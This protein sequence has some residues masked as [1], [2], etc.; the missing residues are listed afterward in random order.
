MID[1]VKNWGH[2]LTEFNE[3]QRKKG[4]LIAK[5]RLEKFDE[6]PAQLKQLLD[7]DDHE[8]AIDFLKPF[9]ETDKQYDGI[10]PGPLSKLFAILD[11]DDP[12]AGMR[13]MLA[14]V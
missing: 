7:D 8:G 5:A 11:S 13:N 14:E 6:I 12:E 3:K 4:F 1:Q 9:V 2:L 10:I